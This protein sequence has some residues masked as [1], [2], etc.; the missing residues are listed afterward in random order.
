MVVVLAAVAGGAVVVPRPSVVVEPPPAVVDVG[1][2]VV[3]VVFVGAVLDEVV[4]SFVVVG[5]GLV[6]EVVVDDVVAVVGVVLVVG[7]VGGTVCANAEDEAST[8]APP[9]RVATLT[10]ARNARRRVVGLGMGSPVGLDGTGRHVL[11]GGESRR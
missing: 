2:A 4:T 9:K 11:E 10:A 7:L 6:V 3:G 1:R 5:D 8:A